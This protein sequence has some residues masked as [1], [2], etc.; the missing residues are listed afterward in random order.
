[1][2]VVVYTYKIRLLRPFLHTLC[3]ARD[4][5]DSG[6][7]NLGNDNFVVLADDADLLAVV[8]LAVEDVGGKETGRILPETNRIHRLVTIL[9]DKKKY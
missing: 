7:L 9:S 3:E 4:Q 5:L 2:L 1:M 8:V 6:P